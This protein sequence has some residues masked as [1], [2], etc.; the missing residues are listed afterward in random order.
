MSAFTVPITVGNPDGGDLA[1]ATAVVDTGAD[2]SLLPA[3]LLAGLGVAPLERMLFVRDDGRRD[4]Y[5]IGI[6]RIAIDGRE[7]PC[8]VVFG[9]DDAYMLGAST[10]EIFNLRADWTRQCLLPEEWL[11]LGGG[12]VSSDG[13]S[14]DGATRAGGALPAPRSVIAGKGYSVLLSYDDG[15]S[16]AVDLS[17]LAGQGVFAAWHDRAFF[18]AVRLSESGG[19]TW[20]NDIDLCPDDLYLRLTGKIAGATGRQR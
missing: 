11:S 2:H 5:G 1:S 3:A 8:P 13:N 15:T 9:P 10:L 17:H 4:E 19:I 7:R 18:E 12:G 20:G 14:S 16:G 6:A